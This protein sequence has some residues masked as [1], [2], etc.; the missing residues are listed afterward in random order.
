MEVQLDLRL[1]NWMKLN[2]L[3]KSW[4]ASNLLTSF[5]IVV[6]LVVTTLVLS[7]MLYSY[8][9]ATTA[10]LAFGTWNIF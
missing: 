2:P 7:A 9:L 5:L 4:L 3:G 1:I 8:V 10:V 6:V